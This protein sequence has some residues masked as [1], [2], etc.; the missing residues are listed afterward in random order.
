MR[1]YSLFTPERCAE[2]VSAIRE[3]QW[4][5]GTTARGNGVKRAQELR[6]DCPAAKPFLDEIIQAVNDSPMYQREML[7][8]A[9]YPR[10]SRYSHGG[11]YRVHSDSA[12]M[13]TVRSDLA[14]TLFLNDD[15]EGGEL[16]I[17]G[18]MPN[19]MEA[20]V[21]LHA[22][23]AVV[24]ECWRPHRVLPVTGERLVAVTWFQ[25]RIASAEDREILDRLH[26]LIDDMDAQKMTDQERFAA[27]GAVHGKLQR[28]F[29]AG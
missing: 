15:Y 28:R 2:I 12:Y 23:Q 26:I 7:E 3:Q 1:V 24:Y 13:G 25:S 5:E 16:C 19:G 14:M 22:G 8:T 17:D 10:F 11:E 9:Y 21:K 6:Q 20:R 18:L 4:T 27:L 29:A